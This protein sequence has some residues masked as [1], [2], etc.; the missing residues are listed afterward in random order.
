MLLWERWS[1]EGLRVAGREIKAPANG[2]AWLEFDPDGVIWGSDGCHPMARPGTVAERDLTVEPAERAF[3]ADGCEPERKEFRDRLQEVFAGR[4]TFRY[5]YQVM[6]LRNERGDH[7]FIRMGRVRNMFG[8][9]YLLDHVTVMDGEWSSVGPPGEA[10]WLRF[11][12]DGT[13]EGGAGCGRFAGRAVFEGDRVAIGPLTV[14]AGGSCAAPVPR[15]FLAHFPGTFT[16][17]CER[18]DGRLDLH[19]DA[20]LGYEEDYTLGFRTV[21]G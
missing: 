4:L 14:A 11:R 15:A 18:N 7:V 20:D 9:R 2:A 10:P 12:G 6:D 1:I 8:R 19:P 21:K 5:K 13:V 3:A 16:W 17:H